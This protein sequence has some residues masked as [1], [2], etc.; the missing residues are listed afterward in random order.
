MI[1]FSFHQWPL[2]ALENKEILHPGLINT[3]YHLRNSDIAPSTL[4]TVSHKLSVLTLATTCKVCYYPHYIDECQ[5][6]YKKLP[7]AP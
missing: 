1:H 4:S 7:K 3:K 5:Q 2:K 6:S